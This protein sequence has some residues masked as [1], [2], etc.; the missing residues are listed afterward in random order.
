MAQTERERLKELLRH[1]ANVAFP[2][3]AR[4]GKYPIIYN[5]CFLRVVYDNLFG[6]KWQ[7]VLG[8]KKPAIHQLD[9]TQLRRATEIGQRLIADR[10]ACETMNRKSLEYRGKI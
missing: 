7:R 10:A 6:E 8:D 9:E 5:H 3:A 1:Q 2:A 4:A